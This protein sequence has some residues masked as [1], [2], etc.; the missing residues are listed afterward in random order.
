MSSNMLDRIRRLMGNAGADPNLASLRVP[1][2]GTKRQRRKTT[3]ENP[4]LSLEEALAR[5][6]AASREA[7]RRIQYEVEVDDGEVMVLVRNAD[8]STV[9][10]RMPAAEAIR[11]AA[12]LAN[13]MGG[14]FEGSL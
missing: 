12:T 4:T 13:G 9:I 14:V 6:R 3:P 5:L 8:D 2:S 1:V 7:G 10:R 11:L